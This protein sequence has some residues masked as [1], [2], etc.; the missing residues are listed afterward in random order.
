MR[1]S[2]TPGGRLLTRTWARGVSATYG[3]HDDGQL[4]S[5]DYSD[6]TPD[7]AFTY[8]YQG[9]LKTASAGAYRYWYDYDER[10]NPKS[11]TINVVASHWISRTYHARALNRCASFSLSGSVGRPVSANY[12]YDAHGRLNR[13]RAS[14]Y[15]I[16]PAP[17]APPELPPAHVPV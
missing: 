4:A 8:A 2:Y 10:L 3:Y 15:P 11:E 6:S 9:A 12:D 14:L 17:P 7:V 13:V 16:R 1:Y 5:I